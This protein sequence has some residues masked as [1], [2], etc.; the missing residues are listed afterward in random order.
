MCP[1]LKA[2]RNAKFF[3]LLPIP[4]RVTIKMNDGTAM[5]SS[6]LD[7]VGFN[8][9]M[10]RWQIT[11]DRLPVELDKIKDVVLQKSWSVHKG[12]F[13]KFVDG[14]SNES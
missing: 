10:N 3:Q 4:V 14:S 13:I 8:R 2:L 12:W 7:F 9:N 11:L 1:N 5:G 6:A